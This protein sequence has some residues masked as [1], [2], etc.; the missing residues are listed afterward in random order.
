MPDR[1]H[2][3]M[4]VFE[5]TDACNQSCKFCYNHFKSQQGYTMDAPNFAMAK[6]S[7][8]TLLQ[9]AEVGSISFSGG[10]P[11]LL[12]RLF[13]LILKARFAGSQV[14]LLTNGTQLTDD[15][16]SFC[17]DLGVEMIQIPILA[18]DAELH[19]SITG[20]TGSWQRA[21]T[22]ARKIAQWDS[23]R[24]IPVFIL[25]ALN[26]D[27][28]LPTLELYR[29]LGV[30][31]IMFNRFNVGGLGI[32]H[33]KALRLT[34]QQLQDT[35]AAASRFLVEN[36]MV[37][38]SGVCSPICILD[39]KHY[40]GIRFAHCNTDV[41]HRPITVNYRGDVRYC[42]HS[43]RVLGNIH[44]EPL[45]QILTQATASGYFD[46]VPDVCAQCSLWSRCRGGCRAASE[47]LYG[48]FDLA[49]PILNG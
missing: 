42:N 43:P 6:K 32:Q 36:N 8:Q 38:N 7:L 3:D 33:W 46:S 4:V 30:K 49:D 24:L 31:Q 22:A 15:A 26:I 5:T 11:L 47:Q 25:S 45:S 29:D 28:T 20:L 2:L 41:S 48:R 16:I 44:R 13:D 21:V 39:P 9:Q 23:S 40:P 19:D 10:E 14:H 12:P 27:Q 18:Q 17:R 35:F 37:A 1:F 34:T